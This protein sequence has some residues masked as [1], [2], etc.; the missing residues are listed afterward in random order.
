MQGILRQV[1]LAH[2]ELD[3]FLD[4]DAVRKTIIDNDAD[5]GD[6]PAF[7]DDVLWSA[8]GARSLSEQYCVDVLQR[9]RTHLVH[10]APPEVV[11]RFDQALIEFGAVAEYVLPPAIAQP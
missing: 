10:H 6:W 3:N 4:A 2:I 8:H 1:F 11:A 5:A 9:G 7:A